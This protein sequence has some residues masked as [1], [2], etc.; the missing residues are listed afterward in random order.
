MSRPPSQS[1]KAVILSQFSSNAVREKLHDPSNATLFT[2]SLKS[3]HFVCAIPIPSLGV[4][5]LISI[6]LLRIS[7]AIQSKK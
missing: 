6:L 7:Q 2:P 1:Q 4:I 5:I 3:P